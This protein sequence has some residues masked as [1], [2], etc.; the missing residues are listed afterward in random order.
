ME[1]FAKNTCST[2]FSIRALVTLLYI[3][4]E[5]VLVALNFP[6]KLTAVQ[7]FLYQ[8]KNNNCHFMP[9]EIFSLKKISS[10]LKIFVSTK[11]LKISKKCCE[12][13]RLLS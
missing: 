6:P 8:T 12:I 7:N 1:L 13:S 2:R 4:P 11:N 10:I 5:K 9:D 3:I